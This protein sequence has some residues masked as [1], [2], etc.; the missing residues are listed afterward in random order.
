MGVLQS[1]RSA[2]SSHHS[3]PLIPPPHRPTPSSS[4]ALAVNHKLS[5]AFLTGKLQCV[6]N[7]MSAAHWLLSLPWDCTIV[8]R[9]K[10]NSITSF[11]KKS[12]NGNASGMASIIVFL[13]LGCNLW[14]S[15]DQMRLFFA[16][17]RL[18]LSSVLLTFRESY[19]T[20]WPNLWPKIYFLGKKL[21]RKVDIGCKRTYLYLQFG[22]PSCVQGNGKKHGFPPE[23]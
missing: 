19:Q 7:Y 18:L 17:L 3:V 16:M 21:K 20:Y 12:A 4:G 11:S 1:F 5:R 23:Q 9:R 10:R 13:L 14:R 22:F 6:Q 8:S 2:A 15:L